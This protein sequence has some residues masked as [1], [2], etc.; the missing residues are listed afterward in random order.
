MQIYCPSDTRDLV[1]QTEISNFA[2]RYR[3]F[4]EWWSDEGK[5]TFGLQARQPNEIPSLSNSQIEPLR[6]R[7]TKAVT[8]LSIK[9]TFLLC[10]LTVGLADGYRTWR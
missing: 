2:L 1:K 4:L 9:W 6:N 10:N 8:I 5:M 3:Y 7:Q